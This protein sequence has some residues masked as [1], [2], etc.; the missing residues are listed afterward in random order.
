MATTENYSE[1]KAEWPSAAELSAQLGPNQLML[2]PDQI[3]ESQGE[4][5]ASFRRDAQELRVSGKEAGLEVTL[6]SPPGARLG[7]YEEHAADWILPVLI[8]IPVQIAT[9]L[10]TNMIQARIDAWRAN[11]GEDSE[12]PSLRYRELEVDGD[13]TRLHEIEG[14][15]DQVRD[16]LRDR[17]AA[18]DE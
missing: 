15:A 11:G 9:T 5:I 4:L 8:S 17:S 3:E 1:P 16:I 14:P 18:A 13:R 10:V 12:I 6:Y 7:V 2:L